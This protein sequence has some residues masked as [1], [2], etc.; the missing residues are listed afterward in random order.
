MDGAMWRKMGW[1]TGTIQY[2]LINRIGRIIGTMLEAS[3]QTAQ[4]RTRTEQ[5]MDL[6]HQ[7]IERRM[8][9]PGARLPSVRA[10]AE[11]TGFSKS[12]IVEAY[13]RLAAEGVIR[14]RVG[15][16]FYVAAPLA[17]W[18]CAM[19]RQKARARSIPYG[20]FAN[21]RTIAQG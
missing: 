20:C 3:S 17:P 18:R 7:R 4:R 10:M 1:R 15:A 14:A 8:L 19:M 12:T 2:N 9:V 16:G 11:S 5:V 6:I 21:V 13:D